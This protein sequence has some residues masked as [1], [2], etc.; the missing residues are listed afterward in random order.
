MTNSL[1]IQAALRRWLEVIM[2]RSMRDWARY[3]K[4][5]GLSMPQFRLLM[6]LYY[7]GPCGITHISDEMSITNAAASQLVD[8]L[9]QSGLLERAEDPHDRRAKQ[10]TISENGR[11]FVQNGIEQRYLWVNELAA[12]LS[13]E[14]CQV[15][16][17]AL[18]ALTEKA[19]SLQA[20]RSATDKTR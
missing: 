1:Q 20:S 13:S 6:E 5:S 8:K 2:T 16:S 19:L 4:S 17:L 15:I 11:T 9:V 14:E 18:T 7:R 3:V 10:V 12:N